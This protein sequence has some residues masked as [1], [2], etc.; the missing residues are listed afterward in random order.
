MK[1][2]RFVPVLILAL[3][4]VL[5]T[6]GA[7]SAAAPARH[8]FGHSYNCTGGDIAA[9][10]YN[11]ILV[12]GVCYM[13]A[14][15]IIVRRDLTVAPGALLDAVT[16]GDPSATPLLPA[17]LLVGGNVSVGRG[18][19]LFLGC[20]P[21]VS[22]PK[23]INYDRIGGSLTAFGA[24]GVVVHSASIGRNVSLLGGGGGVVG[25]VATGVCDG[26]P[27]KGVPAPIPP[28]WASD[29]SLANG[30]GPGMPL[31]VYSDV[32]DNSIG[33]NLSVIGLK[34][35]WLGSIR[36]EVGGNVV[37]AG[38]TMGDPDAMEI[39]NNLVGRSMACFANVPAVQFG[40]GGAAPNI[41]RRFGL[42]QCGF[43]VTQPSPAPTA[44]EGPGVQEHIAVSA[45]SLQTY[46]GAHV[47]TSTTSQVVG[48]TASNTTLVDS[49]NTDNLTGNDGLTGSV[50]EMVAATAYQ[51]GSDSFTAYDTCACSFDGQTGT[52]SIRA[53][54]KTSANGF[55]WGTFLVT[56]GGSSVG[57]G[58]DSL[59]GWG[60]FSSWGEPAG[61]LRLV[62]H[63]RV[64]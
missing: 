40:D 13:P 53:Y 33:G 57:G 31:P 14:G 60:T 32:E 20:S 27:A 2:F 48:T 28:L 18:A 6:A 43:H 29:P 8:R 47:Q 54:G 25:G 12:T 24:L 23:A 52:V 42:G 64:T 19:V 26:D 55:T 11:S 37:F 50:A 21:N 3:S 4:G 45:R 56:S 17:T 63:L 35:C 36:N 34:S 30:E 44:N 39:D 51:N 5:I 10:V 38:N 46:F 58:L 59:A 49:S 22:C 41:V 15:T 7:A 1:A 16:P 9:G 61:T 62:E